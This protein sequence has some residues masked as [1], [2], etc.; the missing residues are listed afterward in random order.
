MDRFIRENDIIVGLTSECIEDLVKGICLCFDWCE[1]YGE[2]GRQAVELIINTWFT[3]KKATLQMFSKHPFWNEDKL[4]IVLPE[5]AYKRSFDKDAYKSFLNLFYSWATE[6]LNEKEILLDGYTYGQLC[7]KISNMGDDIIRLERLVHYDACAKVLEEVRT[8]RKELRDLKDKYNYDIDYQSDGYHMFKADDWN[9]TENV[10]RCF[11][12]LQTIPEQ[13]I[14]ED[15][16]KYINEKVP[17]VKAKRGQKVTTIVRKLA[18]KIGIDTLTNGDLKKMCLGY[19]QFEDDKNMWN[20]KYAQF[21]ETC[22]P[23]DYTR[24]TFISLHPVDYLSMSWLVDT[25]SC[26]TIDKDN[27]HEYKSKR[28]TGY[29]GCSSSGTLS[30]MLDNAS[31]IYYTLGDNAIEKQ[32]ELGEPTPRKEM[33]QMFHLGE[34]KFVQGRLYPDDQTDD[35]RTA[36]PEKYT[37]YR[38]VFQKVISECWNVD[39]LWKPCQS[40]YDACYDATTTD[41]THYPDYLHY[42]NCN[43]SY[44]KTYVDSPKIRIGHN[45]ICPI[46]GEEH[47][48]SAWCTCEDCREEKHTEWCEYHRCYEDV[49]E[50]NMVEVND[51][52]WICEY[53]REQEHF[54]QCARCGE[55]FQEDDCDVVY[56]ERDD[57][58]FCGSYCAEREGYYWNECADD[59]LYE[60]D[61]S[62]SEIEREDL[63]TFDMDYYNLCWAYY[64]EYDGTT[65]ASK[66]SCVEGYDGEWYWED[67]VVE[68]DGEYYPEWSDKI[69]EINGEWY[70]TEDTEENALTGEVLP[71][72][73]A[74]DNDDNAYKDE[75]ECPYVF[76]CWAKYDESD[77]ETI[78][79]IDDC[80]FIN[81]H[82]YMRQICQ[83]VETESV[84]VTKQTFLACNS[85]RGL[86]D[87]DGVMTRIN[88]IEMYEV[89]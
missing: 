64:D 46:C 69:I 36:E 66:S 15:T 65:I 38:A 10:K 8:Q 12:Y 17:S 39:N 2:L 89:A 48:E 62:Y 47:Y 51:Y 1:I 67:I 81:G 31:V 19:I 22:N 80:E 41:G 83:Y 60:D 29:R 33:R 53:G 84:W 6:K 72:T 68:I 23:L 43:V 24:E 44:H 50:E 57:R 35:G 54:V 34:L 56:S 9:T 77:D 76:Y 25:T 52:G 87:V 78:A 32:E 4:A 16:A 79:N 5:Q 11:E 63:P 13:F 14:T 42:K 85:L 59:Y 82:W 58:W 3:N 30:Y 74:L 75:N 18:T 28:I 86:I 49:V 21:C 20:Y 45:P 88:M 26:H 27:K 71:T 70:L 40:G 55:W 61:T 73:E 37:Q 7:N